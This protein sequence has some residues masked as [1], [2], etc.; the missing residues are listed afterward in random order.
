[1]AVDYHTTCGTVRKRLRWRWSSIGKL[2][3]S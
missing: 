2:N 3:N 1:M